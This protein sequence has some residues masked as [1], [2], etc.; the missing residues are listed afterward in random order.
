MSI[1]NRIAKSLAFRS[2]ALFAVLFMNGEKLGRFFSRAEI[3]D[4]VG[5]SNF[6]QTVPGVRVWE[7]GPPAYSLALSRSPESPLSTELD[8]INL[9]YDLSR[10]LKA[11]TV[12]EVGIY[13]GACSL[14]IAQA[15]K[16]NGGGTVHCVDISDA[17][18][19]PIAAAV[20]ELGG[21][22]DAQFL[23][24]DSAAIAA[25]GKLP[26]ANLIFIDADHSYAG[27][28]KDVDEYWPLLMPG[29]AL[30]LHD[31]IMWEGV[32]KTAAELF[33]AG[34]PVISL[35]TSGGSGVTLVFKPLAK[36]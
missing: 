13:K 33:A 27:V 8:V 7:G 17:F 28:R 31:S 36:E 6:F 21:G 35:A 20:K 18:F 3:Q 34:L 23:H 14:A 5:W 16:D 15:L 22:V 30:V 25:A 26:N 12:I 29:G 9:M 10:F 4:V 11:K 19:S 1:F 2:K 32:R 24:G